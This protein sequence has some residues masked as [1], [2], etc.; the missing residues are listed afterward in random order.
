MWMGRAASRLDG[1]AI[2]VT[3]ASSGVGR[4]FVE[5]I[6]RPGMRFA[7][8]ARRKELLDDVAATLARV[9]AE[10][11]VRPCDLRDPDAARAAG[12][13]AVATLGAPD[14]VVACAGHSVARGV[15]AT[16][17]RPDTITRLTAVNHI[18]AVAHLLP[19]ICAMAEVQHGHV[20]GVT[21][22]NARL[23]VP[24]W[25]AYAA[26][27][28]AF[29]TWLMSARPELARVGVATSAVALPLVATPMVAAGRRSQG[30]SAERAADWIARAIVTRAARV[31]P[32]W[33][34][35]VEVLQALA[36]ATTAR[37]IGRFARG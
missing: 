18:G 35:P 32:A 15:L 19:L 33:V 37:L 36:P 25:G 31:A 11:C 22:A 9:G 29:D 4:A 14:V 13:E 23:A 28:A 27:K 2:V 17:D 24:G 1:G 26:S 21:T 6:A 20:V 12:A 8:V 5:G 34:R 16:V 30:M 3:G 10:A 7:L